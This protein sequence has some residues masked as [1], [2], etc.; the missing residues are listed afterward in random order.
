L[1]AVIQSS[2]NLAVTLAGRL[3]QHVGS[4]NVLTGLEDR[5]FYSMDMFS[6][7]T[8]V[9]LVVVPPER[10][11]IGEA[12][13]LCTEAGYAVIPRGGGLSY[14]SGYLSPTSRAVV[15][16]LSR[17]TGII[18]INAEDM[19]V[20]VECGC[21][22]K[23]LN[24]ALSPKG[25]RTPY[26]GPISGGASTVGGAMSQNSI[27]WGS[28]MHGTTADSVLCLEVV[29]ADGTTIVTGSA[30]DRFNPSPFYRT[31][32][33]DLT[34]LFLAD[35]GALGLKLSATFR[36]ITL[37]R[38]NKFASFSYDTHQQLIS[39][40]S[41]ISRAGIASECFGTDA[42]AGS[43]RLKRE[44][45]K[46]DLE[47][48]WG[49][50]KT[51]NTWID[52]LWGAARLAISGRRAFEDVRFAMHVTISADNEV[53]ANQ[54][55]KA[56]RRIGLAQGKEIQPSFP[57]AARGTPF[58]TGN[59]VISADGR[60]YVPT[61]GISPHSRAKPL[62]ADIYAFFDSHKTEMKAQ[63]V[64]WGC[65]TGA[66]GRSAVVI[67]PLIYWGDASR[68]YDQR[69]VTDD[70][71]NRLQQHT[72]SDDRIAVVT[73]LRAGLKDIYKKYGCV[74]LQIGRG[75]PYRETRR[76]DTFALLREIKR[77]VDPK[78]LMNPGSL[79]L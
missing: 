8:L 63:G 79:G 29:I 44:T 41:A 74:H 59:G 28:A 73:M 4:E 64:D 6:E 1:G 14:T 69:L 52:G 77:V 37:P 50:I 35:T 42:F 49:I 46:Q 78:G 7:G 13:R 9:D 56:A 60:R 51:G 30:A 47:Y 72:Q 16:D 27:Y 55:M 20:T 62:I 45:L 54:Q 12:V 21:T 22:W 2:E 39:S 71:R 32:G 76:P 17:L 70:R 67:E 18:E 23:A 11:Q 40:I 3:A 65:I 61:H 19:Y 24:E 57:R 68:L 33:P 5:A 36:L 66:I 75:Y 53:I 10:A 31:Y 43:T 26:F 48:L 25:L 38:I 58:A 15:F 34:G